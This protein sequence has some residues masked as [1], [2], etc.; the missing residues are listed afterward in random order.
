VSQTDKDTDS[1]ESH[2]ERLNRELIE[3]LNELR[4]AL[5]GV[6]VLFAFLLTVPFS[7]RF[8]TITS[9]QRVLYFAT[10][11]GTTISTAMFM[12][13]TS[14]H[15]IRFRQAD[16]ERMLRTS[17]VFAIIGIASMAASITLAITLV[18]D[19][20]FGVGA[21]VAVGAAAL[22]LIGT[23]WFVYPLSRRVRDEA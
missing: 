10:L 9:T 22:A 1:D 4:V 19:L 17:N 23:L 16:K 11:A 3:L 7:N 20:L 12:A 21:A 6:Q 18:A 13:P 2:P 5:P 14:F 8:E 15:R